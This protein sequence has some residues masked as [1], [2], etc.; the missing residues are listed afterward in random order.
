VRSSVFQAE[1]VGFDSHTSCW[2]Q[3]ETERGEAWLSRQ[4]GDLEIAGS[5]PAVLT[6]KSIG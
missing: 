3:N 2:K 1:Q 5:N 4:V 6:D